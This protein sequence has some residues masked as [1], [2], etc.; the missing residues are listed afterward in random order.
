MTPTSGAK[1]PDAQSIVVH[2][3][4]ARGNTQ[5][6]NVP[7][8][9]EV[10]L[11]DNITRYVVGGADASAPSESLGFYFSGMHRRDWNDTDGKGSPEVS[12]QLIV[13]DLSQKDNADNWKNETIP[14]NI[15]GR[16]GAALVWVPVSD[17]GMLVV[18]GGSSD[19]VDLHP[20]FSDPKVDVS[21]LMVSPLI[22]GIY[23]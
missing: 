13:A 9:A 19:L 10:T 3:Q 5:L 2:Q 4:Y 20:D 15:P 11:P 6:S 17:Q 14:D 16:P 1:L 23:C 21:V 22:A 8:T 7:G 18:V 12:Q